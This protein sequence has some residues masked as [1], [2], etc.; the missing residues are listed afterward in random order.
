M[1]HFKR[2]NSA[3]A[4]AA[5]D[6]TSFER[7]PRDQKDGFAFDILIVEDIKISQKISHAALTRGHHFKVE[8]V[9]SGEAALDLF[10]LHVGQLPIILMDIQLPGING[11]QTTETIRQL[12]KAAN[13]ATPVW[14]YALTGNVSAE[15][16]LRYKNAGMNGCILKGNL[17]VASVNR[18]VQASRAGLEFVN[19]C[20]RPNSA[21]SPSSAASSPSPASSRQVSAVTL[22]QAAQPDLLLVE[23]VRVAQ[24]IALNALTR[25]GFKVITADTGELAVEKFRDHRET[26]RYILMDINLPGISGIQA[27]EQ[28]RALEATSAAGSASAPAAGSS[29]AAGESAVLVFGLTGNDDVDSLKHYKAAGMNGC[30]LKGKILAD[31]VKH[32]I[33]ESRQGHFVHIS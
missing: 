13:V 21:G 27:T 20:E 7:S 17:L 8:V 28:I 22:L 19:L 25:A 1:E 14:I 4:A 10:Q 18:A 24:K 23:D 11:I 9:G 5:A 31:A 26:L 33:E 16:L 30:I 12:E 32:A 29:T 3:A 6:E 2:A 15:D